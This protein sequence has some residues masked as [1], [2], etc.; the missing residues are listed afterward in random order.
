[1]KTAPTGN[2]DGQHLAL[3]ATMGHADGDRQLL[4]FLGQM[5]EPVIALFAGNLLRRAICG[6][7][8]KP[9]GEGQG[10]TKSGGCDLH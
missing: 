6:R 9:R 1:M 3:T 10:A 8:D 2:A 4:V 7:R 5:A